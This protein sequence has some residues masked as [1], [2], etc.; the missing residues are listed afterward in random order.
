MQPKAE[1]YFGS[2]ISYKQFLLS[3]QFHYKFGGQAYNQ[4][5]VDRVENADPRFNVDAR[6]LSQRWQ[7]PGDIAL[8]KNIADLGTSYATSRFV[9]RENTIDLPTV[10]VT[11]TLGKKLV[12][13]LG[14]QNLRTLLTV[15]D[16]FYSSS[17]QQERGINYP[18]ARSLTFSIQATL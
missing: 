2:N 7:R 3:F 10:T 1:G 12:Q 16:V 6:A 18:F 14:M 17:I 4:T 9:Q 11:Y 13:K 5:L 15:N 8:F